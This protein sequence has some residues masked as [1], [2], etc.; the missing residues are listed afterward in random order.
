MLRWLVQLFLLLVIYHKTFSY[1]LAYVCSMCSNLEKG[2][3]VVVLRQF[4]FSFLDESKIMDSHAVWD[5][6]L[7][8]VERRYEPYY[9]NPLQ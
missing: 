5:K 4:V 8:V 1:W 2:R 9:N 6:N 7:L 3:H